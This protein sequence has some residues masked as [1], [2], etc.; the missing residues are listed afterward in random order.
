MNFLNHIK[1]NK[2]YGLS[3]FWVIGLSILLICNTTLV[4]AQ[5]THHWGNQFGTRAALLGGAVLT[6]TVDNA[7]VFYNPGNLGYLDTTSLTINANLYGIENIR[8]EN[9]L[10]QRAV[11]YRQ[12]Q[13]GM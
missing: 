11:L 5:D 1:I 12:S 10:G 6:D 7:G 4:K 13:N 3:V 2:R 8:I 9:A